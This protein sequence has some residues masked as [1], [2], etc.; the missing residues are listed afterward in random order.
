MANASARSQVK[1]L[2]DDARIELR[3][4]EAELPS[5]ESRQLWSDISVWSPVPPL[6][7]LQ[8]SAR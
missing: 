5:R 7:P 4:G 8:F 1:H 2:E 3:A 6:G